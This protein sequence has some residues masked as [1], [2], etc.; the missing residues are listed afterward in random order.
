MNFVNSNLTPKAKILEKVAQIPL[1]KLTT[2]GSISKLTGI[3]PR[4]VGWVL[5]GFT[6]QEMQKYPW[7]RVLAKHGIVS[8]LKLGPRGTL[9]IELL[10][11]EGFE[12]EGDQ[13]LDFIDYLDNN[14]N[15][16]LF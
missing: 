3:N 9:Q 5:S 15:I 14:E 4:Q 16:G 12:I 8:S 1:G 7:Q 13:V 6:D 11:Q 2:Y 10:K